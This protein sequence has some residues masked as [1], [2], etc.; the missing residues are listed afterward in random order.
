V[1]LPEPPLPP[2]LQP[3]DIRL[4]SDVGFVAVAAGLHRQAVDTFAVLQLLRPHRAFPYIGEASSHFNE[5]QP[6]EAEK[7]LRRGRKLLDQFAFGARQGTTTAESPVREDA[8]TAQLK[9][10][11]AL[12]AAF[13][14]LALQLSHE[15]S[16]ASQALR[17]ALD[18]EPDGAAARI[19]RTMLGL[20]TDSAPLPSNPI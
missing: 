17:Q 9:E 16:R 1:P 8:E 12:L 18:I 13:H 11:R 5:G 19:A 2:P 6:E 4:L 7:V 15:P 10:D 20:G 14:G 3:D